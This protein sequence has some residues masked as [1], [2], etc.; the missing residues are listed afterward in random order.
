M[1]KIR[2]KIKEYFDKRYNLNYFVEG[3]KYELVNTNGEYISLPNEY[4][5]HGIAQFFIQD[6]N[7]YLYKIYEWFL[8][9]IITFYDN[10]YIKK[11]NLMPR[12]EW[13]DL[14]YF[15]KK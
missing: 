14:Q 12:E 4:L 9:P 7:K 3:Q 5:T 15:S 13:E 2:R 1:K 6:Y 10:Y 11:W 8:Y